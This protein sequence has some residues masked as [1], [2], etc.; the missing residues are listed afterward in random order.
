MTLHAHHI[1]AIGC[2]HC[3]VL[4]CSCSVNCL[5]HI[6]LW[7]ATKKKVAALWVVHQ[8]SHLELSADSWRYYCSAAARSW[9]ASAA[10]S[11][12]IVLYTGNCSSRVAGNDMCC[13]T[14]RAGLPDNLMIA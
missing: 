2:T 7:P 9:Q 13:I 11:C 12:N 6:L 8:N 14:G 5:Q 4:L 10:C 3:G 1:Q